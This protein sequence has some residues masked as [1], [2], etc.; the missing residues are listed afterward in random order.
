MARTQRSATVIITH[1]LHSYR[2]ES[3]FKIWAYR[4][5]EDHEHIFFGGLYANLRA[6]S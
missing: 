4:P 6:C 2:M 1:D 5:Y 3:F